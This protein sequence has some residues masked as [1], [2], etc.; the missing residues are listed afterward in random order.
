M[1]EFIA[2][3]SDVCDPRQDNIRHDLHE[4]L[5]VGLCTMLG[6]PV[7]L[8]GDRVVVFGALAGGGAEEVLRAAGGQRGVAQHRDQ[9]VRGLPGGT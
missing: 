8:L 2:C 7:G 9:R 5:L 3:F 6:G 1:E 4:V